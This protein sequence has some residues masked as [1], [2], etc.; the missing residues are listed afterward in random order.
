[1]ISIIVAI[2]ENRAIGANNGLLWKLPND[3]KRFR[4]ITTG[5]AVVMGRKTFE[6]LPKGALPNRTN[7]VVTKNKEALFENCKIFNNIRDAVKEYNSGEEVFIIGGASIYGQTIDLADK[8]YITRV[9]HSF[10]NADIFF[11]E[12][13]EDKW[14]MTEQ[15]DF[16]NDDK[17]LYP[18][19]FQTYIR[20]K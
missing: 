8:M 9:H 12:I 10:E 18:Y 11:P 15:E 2:A 5:H 13:D 1:M 14:M 3:M 6:S 4:E 17:H 19:T 16:R 20:K 7:I